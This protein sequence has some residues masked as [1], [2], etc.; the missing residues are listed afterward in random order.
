M[1]SQLVHIT[2]A[3]IVKGKK[4]EVD[5]VCV[6]FVKVRGLQR[7]PGQGPQTDGEMEQGPPTDIYCIK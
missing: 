1:L 7:F 4:N 2:G 3:F 6:A 5:L